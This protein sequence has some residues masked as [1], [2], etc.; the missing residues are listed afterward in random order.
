MQIGDWGNVLIRHVCEQKHWKYSP[1]ACP[2]SGVEFHGTFQFQKIIFLQLLQKLILF[3]VWYWPIMNAH[4]NW[5]SN[6]MTKCF[7]RIWL[8]VKNLTP[9][10]RYGFFLVLVLIGSHSLCNSFVVN[11]FLFSHQMEKISF[12]IHPRSDE[13]NM[14]GKKFFVYFLLAKYTPMSHKNSG[15]KQEWLYPTACVGSY[16]IPDKNIQTYLICLQSC[17]M[18]KHQKANLRTAEYVYNNDGWKWAL[19]TFHDPS[20]HE[21]HVHFQLAQDQRCEPGKTLLL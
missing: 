4:T 9:H 7:K 16:F 10:L 1:W 15:Q 18:Q 5:Q 12:V 2:F 19:R 3:P 17:N 6:N 11:Q 21:T 20:H 8:T 13:S 14:V